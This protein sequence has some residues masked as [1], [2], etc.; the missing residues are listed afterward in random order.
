MGVLK[1]W[2]YS[3][4]SGRIKFLKA[5]KYLE[6]YYISRGLQIKTQTQEM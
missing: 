1:E 5:P 6:I 3:L 2:K 4:I